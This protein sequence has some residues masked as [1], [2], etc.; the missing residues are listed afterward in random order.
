[1]T[2]F[3]TVHKNKVK[4]GSKEACISLYIFLPGNPLPAW[5]KLVP[6]AVPIVEVV[7]F[8]IEVKRVIF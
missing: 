4:F 7:I 5:H 6:I 8:V 2:F 3:K 1:M